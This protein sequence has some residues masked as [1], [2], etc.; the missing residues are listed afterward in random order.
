M[1]W[2]HV[3]LEAA[4]IYI[5]T[6]SIQQ[7]GTHSS[8]V[9]SNYLLKHKCS[10]IRACIMCRGHVVLWH[11]VVVCSAV[12]EQTLL[13]SRFTDR[14]TLQAASQGSA[15]PTSSLAESPIMIAS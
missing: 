15:A 9:T 8:S 10:A 4:L 6:S 1:S 3:S 13:G 14:Q 12:L 11:F 2:L 7:D 5:R